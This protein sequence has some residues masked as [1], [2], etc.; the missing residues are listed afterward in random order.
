M[1]QVERL[2]KT[3]GTHVALREVT[4]QVSRGEVVG[5]LGRNGAGKTTTLRILAGV[6]RPTAGRVSFDGQDCATDP[7]RAR[8]TIGYLPEAAALYPEL[9][10]E[11]HLVAR[12]AQKGVA[13]RERS[14]RVKWALSQVNARS[15]EQVLCGNLS[16]G[17]RQRVAM[18]DALLKDAPIL[19]LDEPTAGLDPS[20]TRETRE[21][22]RRLGETRTV[23]V[24]SHL[25]AEV[26][27][28]CD[29]VI[30]IDRG[31]VV[32]RGTLTELR[33][34]SRA[35]E[36]TLTL[37]TSRHSAEAALSQSAATSLTYEEPEPGIVRVVIG[38]PPDTDLDT[39]A[40]AT[41]RIVTSHGIPVRGLTH[42]T[43]SLEQIFAALTSSHPE[44][45]S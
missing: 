13:R 3:Y 15:F 11:E 35:A 9:R 39:L 17:M 14:G 41:T 4:F 21:L 12:A 44:E 20:Q 31:A 5:L 25:L 16:R 34:L 42:K 32:G 45:K 18:A 36:L 43:A 6:L 1:I 28:L 38:C 26:E 37:R 23:V 19:L 8:G 22:I 30:V 7:L 10:V 24:S 40:E 33:Q 29:S 2:N 27:V